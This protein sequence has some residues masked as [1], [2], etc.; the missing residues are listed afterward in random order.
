MKLWSFIS[1]LALAAI[2]VQA[3]GI[4]PGDSYE[5]VIA[6]LGQPKGEISSGTYRLL[7]YERGKVELRGG[8][9][10]KA[11]IISAEEL[12]EKKLLRERKLA[13]TQKAN[14]EAR[15]H[16]IVEGTAIRK[17]KLADTAF[18]NSTA[19][20]RVAFWQAFKK[21][22][23]EVSLG[24]EY[25]TALK[26]LELQYAAQRVDIAQQQRIDELEQRVRAAEQ[27]SHSAESHGVQVYYDSPVVYGGYFPGGMT[28]DCSSPPRRHEPSHRASNFL[29]VP[30]SYTSRDMGAPFNRNLESSPFRCESIA[31]HYLVEPFSGLGF[32]FNFGSR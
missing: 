22:Y 23:P 29:P 4:K 32:S 20:E 9:V 28:F 2:A 8:K 1:F 31:P 12:A 27:R 3:D 26:E 19:G 24:D 25:S 13:E 16:R 7:D 11:E 17:S 21:Q 18:M 15:A 5:Q 6:V 14:E 30:F 10:S